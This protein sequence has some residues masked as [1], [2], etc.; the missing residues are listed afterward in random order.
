MSYSDPMNSLRYVG[1]E[2]TVQALGAPYQHLF[3]PQTIKKISTK[4]TQL[5]KGVDP[6]GRNIVYPEHR[7][8]EIMG[9]VLTYYQRPG[10]GDIYTKYI[11]PNETPRNDFE[12]IINQSI[13]IIVKAL[14]TEMEMEN[15]N[16][17]LS[18]WN[19]VLGDFNEKGLRAHPVL[20]I[21]KNRPQP[22]MFNMNY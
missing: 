15:N 1:W 5:L 21:K 10:I 14:K 16:T 18:I 8:K 13:N 2:N 20:K 7:I 4:I 22:M 9:K 12:F 6:A 17:K 3:E 11:I 19:S